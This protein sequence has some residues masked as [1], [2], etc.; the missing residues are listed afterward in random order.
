MRISIT[1]LLR[2][3]GIRVE[4]SVYR[5]DAEAVLEYEFDIG[6][7]VEA[8]AGDSPAGQGYYD[9]LAFD[10]EERSA[11]QRL[12]APHKKQLAELAAASERMRS[13]PAELRNEKQR[14]LAEKRRKIRNDLKRIEAEIHEDIVR[15]HGFDPAELQCF[16][17]RK[18]ASLTTFEHIMR[19]LPALRAVGSQPMRTAPWL[20][21][22]L[23]QLRNAVH[24]GANIGIVGG[25]CLFGMHEVLLELEMDYGPECFDCSCG[26]RHTQVNEAEAEGELTLDAFFRQEAERVRSVRIVN[27]K[28]GITYQEY[29]NLVYVF[30]VAAVLG[31]VV[32]IPLPDMSYLK[33]MAAATQPLAQPLRSELMEAYTCEVLKISD[34]FLALIESLKKR[35][36]TLE[37]KV[38]HLR[39]AEMCAAYYAKRE[40]YITKPQFIRKLTRSG[41]RMQAVI[42]YITMLALPYYLDG[43]REIIQIDNLEETD[44]GKKCQ[45][46]H[47]GDMTLHSLLYPEVFSMDGVNTIYNTKIE[48]KNYMS[49]G[50]FFGE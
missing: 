11:V 14:E 12:C 46:L 2:L 18:R 27:R 49:E 10:E 50:E 31:G 47:G 7:Y 1:E 17:Y 38:L 42:D 4:N 26:R 6:N 40:P 35:Y 21:T 24:S 44:S 37:I 15:R 20:A 5:D 39:D 32:H 19:A 33:Q 34:M 43:V 23:A 8:E 45:K 28:T 13:E 48:N 29:I 30:D 9:I 16:E 41:W 25:P 22:N 3:H 36:P